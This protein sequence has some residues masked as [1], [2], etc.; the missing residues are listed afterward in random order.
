MESGAD[1]ILSPCISLSESKHNIYLTS[2]ETWRS[3]FYSLCSK[4]LEPTG[5]KGFV[6]LGSLQFLKPGFKLFYSQDPLTKQ[7]YKVMTIIV[8]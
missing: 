8:F 6:M 4:A 5:L 7:F 1:I 2:V 3:S